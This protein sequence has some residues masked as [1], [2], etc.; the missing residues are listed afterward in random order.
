[1]QHGMLF[2]GAIMLI[3]IGLL[4]S[5]VQAN[6]PLVAADF[7]HLTS[8]QKQTLASLYKSKPSNYLLTQYGSGQGQRFLQSGS[9]S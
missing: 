7:N 3:A 1:M 4:V 8:C 9:C 2:G 5:V 6:Q